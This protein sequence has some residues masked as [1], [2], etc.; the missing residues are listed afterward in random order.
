MEACCSSYRQ[1]LFLDPIAVHFLNLETSATRFARDPLVYYMTVWNPFWTLGFFSWISS[2][3]MSEA[4]QMIRIPVQHQSLEN[5]NMEHKIEEW[6]ILDPHSVI[7]FLFEDGKLS[8]PDVDVHR[9]WKHH[10]EHGEPWAA[11]SSLHHMVPLGI[12]GD[13]ARCATQFNSVNIIGIFLKCVLW[14]PCSIRTSRYLLFAIE[15]EKLWGYHTLNAVLRRITWSLNACFCGIH[16][17]VD[18]Y[19]KELPDKMKKLAGVPLTSAHLRFCLTEIRGDW[20]WHKKIWRFPKVS[21][22]GISI[23]YHCRAKSK[24]HW[25]DLYWNLTEG[26]SWDNNDFSLGEFLE[27]RLPS[28]GICALGSVWATNQLM[29][30]NQV[31]A[32][33][34]RGLF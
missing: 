2:L 8:I 15:E 14:R 3:H 29:T 13:A 27:E 28:R 6:P 4:I 17:S 7:H 34:P 9:Y 24:G 30:T 26:S 20:S 11:D 1:N 18:H 16:P 33:W 12:F 5:G 10:S 32:S 21:W 31:Y 23:C 19:G 22:N 25:C